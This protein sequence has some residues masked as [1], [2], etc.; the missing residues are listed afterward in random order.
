MRK[1][2]GSMLGENIDEDYNENK[3]SQ[4]QAVLKNPMRYHATDRRYLE[5]PNNVYGAEEPSVEKE[6]TSSLGGWLVNSHLGDITSSERQL[7]LERPTQRDEPS[8]AVTVPPTARG[9]TS[10]DFSKEMFQTPADRAQDLISTGSLINTYTGEVITTLENDMPPPDREAGEIVHENKA[11]Q[12]RLLAASGNPRST[13]PKKE[14][15]NSIPAGDTGKIS[16]ESSILASANVR[17]EGEERNARDAYFNKNGMAPTEMEMSRNPVN[18]DGYNNRVR[19]KPYLPYTQELDTKDWI[20]NSSQLSTHETIQIPK[21][22]LHDDALPGRLGLAANTSPENTQIISKVRV[23]VTQRNKDGEHM[24]APVEQS[25]QGGN[26]P[27]AQNCRKDDSATLLLPS[28]MQGNI[29]TH[30]SGTSSLTSESVMSTLR[31]SLFPSVTREVLPQANGASALA[32]EEQRKPETHTGFMKRPQNAPVGHMPTVSEVS[33]HV[34]KHFPVNETRATGLP[35]EN[36]RISIS[37]VETQKEH[38]GFDNID[39]NVNIGISPNTAVS[40]VHVKVPEWLDSMNNRGAGRES[41]LHVVT[42]EHSKNLERGSSIDVQAQARNATIPSWLAS[43]SHTSSHDFKATELCPNGIRGEAEP[44][45]TMANIS[46]AKFKKE[47]VQHKNPAPHASAEAQSANVSALLTPCNPLPPVDFGHAVH[48]VTGRRKEGI[49]QVKSHR[50]H[51]DLHRKAHQKVGGDTLENPRFRFVPGYRDM[52]AEII[53]SPSGQL[54]MGD[55]YLTER[56]SLGR[57]PTPVK[58]EPK[59]VYSPKPTY[60]I[61][62]GIVT[63]LTDGLGSRCENDD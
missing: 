7:K 16:T 20:A 3:Y 4:K 12:L 37:E 2:L 6:K 40:S 57:F 28:H 15:E 51:H 5:Q 52:R 43:S 45:G 62:S 60:K 10:A 59:R 9:N 61:K 49:I 63:A 56:A 32:S 18:Y 19:F 42:G 58:R 8:L 53:I 29:D 14:L 55:M 54:Q 39:R 24:N 1:I 44:N 36:A 17:R 33:K 25:T 27:R 38:V 35:D 31:G 26:V 48:T 13:R 30:S 46:A 11:K 21:T 34:E 23:N 41:T 47:R 50:G 22:R